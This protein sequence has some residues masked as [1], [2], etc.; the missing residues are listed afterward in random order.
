[1][2]ALPDWETL[3]LR[4]QI[5]QMIVVRASGHLFDHQIEYPQWEAP[6]AVLQRSIQ[7]LGVGGVIL[8]GG[9]AA[10]IGLRTQQL[11]DWA[12]IPLVI[13]AD[14]EEGVGE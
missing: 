7:E 11:Q 9:S 2:S 5:A 12:E 13:A 1:M 10:E 8:L 4:Q 6:H 3:S 14:I